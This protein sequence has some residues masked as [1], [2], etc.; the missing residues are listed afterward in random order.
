[1]QGRDYTKDT[2]I[3]D[4]VAVITGGNAGIGKQTAI[5]LARRGGKVYIAC[6]DQERAETALKE[7][8]ER[9]GSDNVHYLQLDLASL[10]SVREFSKNFHQLE[11]KLHILVNNA[12]VMACA[13][14]QTKDGFE[15]HMGTNHLGHFLLT[16]LL[17]DLLKAGAPSRVVVVAS[18]FHIVGKIKQKD[19]LS[20]KFYFRWFAY[21]SSKLA[22]ILFTRELAKKLEGTGVTAN[23]LHPGE[24]NQVVD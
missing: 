13:K 5:D 2:K 12:G 1:M 19:F 22:N 11:E 21:A 6:R 23:S 16:N 24:F 3:P 4:R 17:L 10:D 7:I 15:M 20:E 18:L 8:K 14:S 9:S